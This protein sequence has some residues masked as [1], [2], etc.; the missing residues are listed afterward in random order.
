[1]ARALAGIIDVLDPDVI[2]LGG[3]LSNID[4]LCVNAPRPKG[5]AIQELCD[6]GETACDPRS[7]RFGGF[8]CPVVEAFAAGEVTA[9]ISPRAR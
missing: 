2:A 5:S 9:R 8:G 4:R 1:M 3:G 7:S 6:G